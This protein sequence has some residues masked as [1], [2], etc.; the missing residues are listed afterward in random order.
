MVGRRE[1]VEYVHCLD[2]GQ[3]YEAEDLEPVLAGEDE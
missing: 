3:V 1:G 2:C